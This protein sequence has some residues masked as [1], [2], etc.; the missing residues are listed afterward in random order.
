MTPYAAP[1]RGRLFLGP[2]ATVLGGVATLGRAATVLGG[3][4]WLLGRSGTDHGGFGV[5]LGGVGR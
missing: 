5:V 2:S 3:V 1:P 4:D